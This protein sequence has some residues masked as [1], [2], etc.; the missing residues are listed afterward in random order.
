MRTVPA[1]GTPRLLP[2]ALSFESVSVRYRGSET[3]ALVDA[4]LRVAA[5]GKTVIVGPN[6]SGKSTLL[7]A[8]LGL[9]PVSRGTVRVLGQDVRSVRGAT[10]VGTNLDEVYRLLTLPVDRLITLWAKLKGG[11]ETEVRGWIDG[12]GLKSALDRPLFRLSTGQ[13]KLVGNLLALG[14]SSELLL[15]DEPFDNVDF[16]RRRKLIELLSRSG[17]A[18]AMNTHELDLLHSFPDW[19]LYFMFEG[20]L[21]GRFHA[22]DIDRLYVSR[23]V[24]P[25]A[26]S[27]FRSAIGEISVTLDSGDFPMKGA[28]NLSYLLDRIA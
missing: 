20:Q 6:G 8:A 27:T 28:S 2:G 19:D 26:L 22:R 25:G 7:R 18:V 13:M 4:S 14:F 5:G 3:D 1:A 11:S 10:G 9:T 16:G 21:V 12:F 24:R 23:G 17:A 15:L